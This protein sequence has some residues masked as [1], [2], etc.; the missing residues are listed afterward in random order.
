MLLGFQQL[1]EGWKKRSEGRRER[2]REKDGKENHLD[3]QAKVCLHLHKRINWPGCR[4]LHSNIQCQKQWSN[5]QALRKESAIPSGYTLL[6]YL[7]SIRVQIRDKGL[8]KRVCQFPMAVVRNCRKLSGLR[9]QK[10]ILST[11]WRP[12]SEISTT[13]LKSRCS[14]GC[15]PSRGSK[16]D[17]V[18]CLFSFLVAASTP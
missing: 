8:I 15:A 4:I 3:I 5:T 7:R 14:Q 18:P 16:G 12:E 6:P 17:F 1:K 2:G 11:S 9:Q 13:E 10:F